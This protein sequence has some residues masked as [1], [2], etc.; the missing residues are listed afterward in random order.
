MTLRTLGLVLL[1]SLGANMLLAG[2]VIGDRI[3]HPA[4]AAAPAAHRAPGAANPAANP[5]A[6]IN[7]LPPDEQRAFR[8]AMRAY[9]PAIAGLQ[10][11]VRAAQAAVAD[12]VRADPYD[13]GA[14][15]DAFARLRA[16]QSRAQ[17]KA[18]DA[19]ASAFAAL[20]PASRAQLA[21]PRERAP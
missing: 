19:A 8:R 6:H 15:R 1:G 5:L 2:F 11:E 14:V 9:R 3:T 16:A 13:E 17:E 10:A 7:D 21:T 4:V 20:S 12:A 18:Q